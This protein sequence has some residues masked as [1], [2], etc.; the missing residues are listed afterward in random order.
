M[1]NSTWVMM[2]QET[3]RLSKMP[4]EV[5]AEIAPWFIEKQ[6]IEEESP[7]K[8]EKLD[9]NAR[10]VHSNLKVCLV[11][12]RTEL[13]PTEL[14]SLMLSVVVQPKRS[15]L[16]MNHHVN[17]VKYVRW[18]LEVRTKP[19]LLGSSY[20]VIIIKLNWL[21]LIFRQSQMNSWKIISSQV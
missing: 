11:N 10:Y 9:S 3:R 2:N 17:N 20:S 12:N 13:N 8:I 7:E 15:D 21:R 19:E 18:M 14:I 1:E 6:A 5:R 4:D 16:D